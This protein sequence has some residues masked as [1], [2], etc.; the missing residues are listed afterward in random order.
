MWPQAHAFSED[1]TA[2]CEL[3]DS[4]ANGKPPHFYQQLLTS[5]SRLARSA[6][7]LPQVCSSEEVECGGHRMTHDEWGL[8]ARR[9][10]DVVGR[11]VAELMATDDAKTASSVRAVML[12]DDLA[13]IYRDLRD[14]MRFYCLKTDKGIEEAIWQWRFDYEAHWGQHLFD[15]LHTVHR[16]RYE[17]HE[18]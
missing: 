1:A 9:L 11:E 5:M 2:Y 13:D 18:D 3:I 12:F 15:A 6:N 7:E 4:A 10:S 17:L 14:G 8:L 16:I